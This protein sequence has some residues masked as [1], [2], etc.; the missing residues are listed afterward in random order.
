MLASTRMR[1]VR[2]GQLD[3]RGTGLPLD[4]L[5]RIWRMVSNNVIV[6]IQSIFRGQRGRRRAGEA[7]RMAREARMWD[8]FAGTDRSNPPPEVA[9]LRNDPYNDP[10]NF[11]TLRAAYDQ[12]RFGR[13]VW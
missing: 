2:T 3:N 9:A 6:T 1:M 4:V 8:Y 5:Q 10:W 11:N 13:S 7:R 12:D